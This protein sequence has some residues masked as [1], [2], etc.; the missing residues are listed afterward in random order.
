MIHVDRKF[1]IQFLSNSFSSANF[2]PYIDS[3][4][5]L[6]SLALLEKFTLTFCTSD[7]TI[8]L[9]LHLL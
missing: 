2:T 1:E 9:F 8:D 6:G 3:E 5:L 7:N 4:Y